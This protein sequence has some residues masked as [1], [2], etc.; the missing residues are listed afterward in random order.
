MITDE[1]RK[2][3]EIDKDGNVTEQS[4]RYL[5]FLTREGGHSTM[6]GLPYFHR[7]V[8][9]KK[10]TVTLADINNAEVTLTYKQIIKGG[11]END[12]LSLRY[13]ELLK[14]NVLTFGEQCRRSEAALLAH[15]RCAHKLQWLIQEEANNFQKFLGYAQ[16]MGIEI[17][18]LPD[19]RVIDCATLRVLGTTAPELPRVIVGAK[20]SSS[21]A[22]A[23]AITTAKP[24]QPLHTDDEILIAMAKEYEK[25]ERK[26]KAA[27]LPVPEEMEFEYDPRNQIQ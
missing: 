11:E 13:R 7:G 9:R 19:G 10:K 24:A 27:G 25:Q 2:L 26:L 8:D 3:W 16:R 1:S 15:T 12:P 21:E 18:V 5:E 17:S 23:A 20:I 14:A 6:D 22:A 4:L